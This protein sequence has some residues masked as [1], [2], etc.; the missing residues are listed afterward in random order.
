MFSGMFLNDNNYN[1][2]VFI[3][4]YLNWYRWSI[5]MDESSIM[6]C[7]YESM[8]GNFLIF[9]LDTSTRKPSSFNFPGRKTYW[10][11]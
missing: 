4:P 3:R 2:D 7:E 5:K 8:T 11:I 9:V 6:L 1:Y 10:T